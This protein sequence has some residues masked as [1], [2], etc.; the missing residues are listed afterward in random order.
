[1]AFYRHSEVAR[2]QL[3]STCLQGTALRWYNNLP[4]RSI[5]SWTTLKTKFQTRFSSNYKGG[6]ITA[7][8]IMMRQRPSESLR[9]YL[10]HF[11]QAISEITDL[12]ESL[13]MNYL[14]TGIDGSRHGILIE[15]LIEKLPRH[16]HAAFQ[17]VEHRMTLQE[18][19]GSIRS[20]R[21]SSYKYD[22]SRA[23]SPQ[24]PRSRG[25]NSKSPRHSPAR[26]DNRKEE[27]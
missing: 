8:L 20:P 19:V 18:A 25:Y 10:G 13:A 3:F 9:S 26:R 22:R 27:H 17:I 7:S 2:C 11:R 4:F 16:L 6:K 1:M 24:T 23:H 21:R 14:A 12:E 15:E 5:G